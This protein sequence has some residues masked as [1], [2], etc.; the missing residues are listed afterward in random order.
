MNLRG[1]VDTKNIETQSNISKE[2]IVRDK[3]VSENHHR[4]SQNEN[5]E[6]IDFSAIKEKIKGVF[7]KTKDTYQ[8]QHKMDEEVSINLNDIKDFF[9]TN[10]KWLFPLLFII[11]ALFSS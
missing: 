7:S 10:A 9:K 5:D 4:N 6:E 2:E 3:K 1:F 8:Q 11:I